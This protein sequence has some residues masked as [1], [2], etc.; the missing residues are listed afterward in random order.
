VLHNTFPD[1]TS[2]TT[3]RQAAQDSANVC[4]IVPAA[5]RDTVYCTYLVLSTPLMA[6]PRGNCDSRISC[7]KPLRV[8]QPF[9]TNSVPYNAHCATRCDSDTCT[10]P[11]DPSCCTPIN[12]LLLHHCSLLFCL[13]VM[14]GSTLHKSMIHKAMYTSCYKIYISCT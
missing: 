11:A 5:A 12:K 10:S 8:T 14:V 1:D 13:C 2:A 6:N 9:S 7:F 3:V 4:R